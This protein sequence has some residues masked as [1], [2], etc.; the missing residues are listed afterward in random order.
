MW[1]LRGAAVPFLPRGQ[2]LALPGGCLE[3]GGVGWGGVGW[4]GVGWG[5]VRWGGLGWGDGG[6]SLGSSA[7]AAQGSQ[8]ASHLLLWP[9]PISTHPP[10]LLPLLLLLLLPLEQGV[11]EFQCYDRRALASL[12]AAA[13]SAGHPEWG[14]SGPQDTGSYNST[15][16]VHSRQHMAPV[17]SCLGVWSVRHT[18]RGCRGHDSLVRAQ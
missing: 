4:G 6:S 5:G 8:D 11:G 13:R 17:L 1:A 16:E 10:L 12:A 3:D 15:P 9:L 18:P 7:M 2:R 14:H